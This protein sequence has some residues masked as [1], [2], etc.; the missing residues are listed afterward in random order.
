MGGPAHDIDMDPPSGIPFDGRASDVQDLYGPRIQS[1]PHGVRLT[2]THDMRTA[3]GTFS[4]PAILEPMHVIGFLLLEL[5]GFL[6]LLRTDDV[7]G[8]TG[9]VSWA[10]RNLGGAGTHTLYKLIGVGLIILGLLW[11]TGLFERIFSGFLVGL[12]GGFGG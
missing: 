10:E 6:F 5:F 7:V 2:T 11:V 8:F 4:F 12:F 1:R 3:R 9:R